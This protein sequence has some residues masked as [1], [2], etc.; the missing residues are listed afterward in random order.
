MISVVKKIGQKVINDFR[1]F[2]T[3]SNDVIKAISVGDSEKLN[4]LSSKF[5]ENAAIGVGVVLTK[6]IGFGAIVDVA[7]GRS[8]TDSLTEDTIFNINPVIETMVAAN[9]VMAGVSKAAAV[10]NFGNDTRSLKFYLVNL[11]GKDIISEETYNET[12]KKVEACS[13]AKERE[14][15]VVDL[16]SELPAEDIV[17]IA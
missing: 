5:A 14:Q 13:T 17:K 11:L 15:V 2:F 4:E 8:V 12:V 9:V 10:A 16:I 1:T 6:K 3:N 7:N